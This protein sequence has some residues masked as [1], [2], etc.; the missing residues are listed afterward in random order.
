MQIPA[1]RERSKRHDCPLSVS[2]PLVSWFDWVVVSV[3]LEQNMIHCNLFELGVVV[4]DSESQEKVKGSEKN[5]NVAHSPLEC[6]VAPL[7]EVNKERDAQQDALEGAHKDCRRD[8]NADLPCTPCECGTGDRPDQ[9]VK[10]ECI[11]C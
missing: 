8:Q 6:S 3:V 5:P 1:G 9:K 4:E 10:H 7:F 2:V 11:A